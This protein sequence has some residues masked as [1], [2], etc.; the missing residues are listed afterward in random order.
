MKKNT[1]NLYTNSDLLNPLKSANSF[2]GPVLT[3]GPKSAGP[4]QTNKNKLAIEIVDFRF[5]AHVGILILMVGFGLK[6]TTVIEN[7]EKSYTHPEVLKI[8]TSGG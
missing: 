1:V 7:D 8:L 4:F 6:S 5:Q 3:G 2:G